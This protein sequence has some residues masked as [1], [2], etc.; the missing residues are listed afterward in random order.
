MTG[1]VVWLTGPPASGKTTLARHLVTRLR[2]QGREPVLLDGDEVRGALSPALGHDPVGRDHFYRT[3]AALAALLAHQ[4][5]LV[6]VAATAHERR[7]RDAARARAP[8][9]VEVHVATPLAE[10]QRRDPK[11]LY[12]AEVEQLPGHD[13][14]YEPPLAPEVTALPDAA[15]AALD[16]II[17][18]LDA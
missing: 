3:L 18:R 5:L 4:G 14:P 12:R 8:R 2:A 9:F 7:W 13:L 11:G 1:A 16:A 10:C 6:V 15:E 17:A